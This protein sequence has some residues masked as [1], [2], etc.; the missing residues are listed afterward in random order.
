MQIKYREASRLK[1]K[2]RGLYHL[3]FICKVQSCIYALLLT[4]V[5]CVIENYLLVVFTNWM[6]TRQ[7][8]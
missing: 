7:K 1:Y 6:I 8:L 2:I 4:I 5:L 3:W